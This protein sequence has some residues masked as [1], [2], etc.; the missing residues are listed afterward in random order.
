MVFD[1]LKK[2]DLHWIRKQMKTKL[3]AEFYEKIEED[4]LHN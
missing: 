2:K 1:K 3:L 4:V